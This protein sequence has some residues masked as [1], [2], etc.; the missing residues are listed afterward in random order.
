VAFLE[1][2]AGELVEVVDLPMTRSSM[3]AVSKP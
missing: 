2:L 1:H 3:W